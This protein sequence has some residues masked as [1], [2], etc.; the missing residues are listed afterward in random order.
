MANLLVET[1]IAIRNYIKVLA[2]NEYIKRICADKNSKLNQLPC[3]ESTGRLIEKIK[4]KSSIVLSYGMF[5]KGVMYT[6]I[7]SSLVF[8]VLILIITLYCI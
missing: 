4:L 2:D 6:L 3:T 8:D 1:S 5:T 7:K